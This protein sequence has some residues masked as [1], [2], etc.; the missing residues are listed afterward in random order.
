MKIRSVEAELFLEDRRMDGNDEANNFSQFCERAHKPHT[1]QN[2][3]SKVEGH[4]SSKIRKTNIYNSKYHIITSF[5]NNKIC[6]LAW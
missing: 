5:N 3:R 2:T 1:S 6:R 4:L